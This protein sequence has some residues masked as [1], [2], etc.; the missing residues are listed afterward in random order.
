MQLTDITRID[1]TVFARFDPKPHQ[2]GF[3]NVMHGGVAAA[4]LDEAMSYACVLLTG[5]WCATV[6]TEIRYRHVTTLDAPLRVEAG[7][8]KGVGGR[9][10]STWARLK[11][12]D[13]TITVEAS[14][15]FLPVPHELFGEF[16]P[17]HLAVQ[18]AV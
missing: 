2:Q 10:Y 13:E 9:R 3:P 14:A 12:L 18:S 8:S 5:N 17:P 6:K 7:I 15:I 11:R 4:V 16:V 1:D